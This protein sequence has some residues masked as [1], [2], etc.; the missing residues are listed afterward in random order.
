M[1]DD[2]AFALQLADLADSISLTRFGATDLQVETKP[3]LTP[4]SDADR[5]V[6]EA[7]RIA[8]GAG[9]PGEAVLGEEL[10][11]GAGDEAA[12]WVLDPIDGTRNFVRGIPIWATLIALERDGEL[13]ASVASAPAL[14]RRWWASRGGGAFA[15]GSA[16]RVSGVR[17]IEDATFCY[18]SAR[19]FARAGLSDRFLELAGRAWVERGFG[20][21]WMHVLVA[22][23]AADV[24]VDTALERWDVA[25][26]QLIVEEA[27]GRFSA[28]D[29]SPHVPGAPALSTNGALHDAIV[30]AFTS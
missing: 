2:L 19:S 18:T 25:A 1:D 8:I 6:E 27:G 9:R 3:D 14:G 10:G 17:R 5:A 29:G 4:V 16:I 15:D 23:G 7:L 26:V 24:A 30:A 22:E 20:D 13:A 12:L 11:V 28:L 21:F